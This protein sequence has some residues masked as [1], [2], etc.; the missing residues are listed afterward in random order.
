MCLL[1][2]KGTWN[3]VFRYR[4]QASRQA[5]KQ[6][7]KQ[8]PAATGCQKCSATHSCNHVIHNECAENVSPSSH[9]TMA[10]RGFSG[11]LFPMFL[12]QYNTLSLFPKIFVRRSVCAPEQRLLRTSLSSLP[13][14]IG[15]TPVGFITYSIY[16][17]RVWYSR[18]LTSCGCRCW[19][20]DRAEG[21][22]LVDGCCKIL[23]RILSVYCADHIVLDCSMR[24]CGYH[25]AVLL[26]PRGRSWVSMYD[27][28]SVW[29][30]SAGSKVWRCVET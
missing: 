24:W 21:R 11:F 14:Y 25:R 18:V 6:T 10:W 22:F 13:S 4:M 30:H 8:E 26:I 29:S 20:A 19:K 1:T 7:D 23:V 2:G 16:I 3:T 27:N 28:V 12:L 9:H 17:S 5:D 15:R